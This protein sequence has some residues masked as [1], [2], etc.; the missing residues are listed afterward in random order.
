MAGR[1]ILITGASSGIGRATAERLGAQGDTLLLLARNE[2][3]LAEVATAIAAKGGRAT[4]FPVDLSDPAA[5]DE[6]T[7]RIR[8]VHGTPDI[9]VNNAGAGRWLPV[10]ETAIAEARAMMELPYL[11][12]FQVTRAFL[13]DMTARGSGLVAFVTS[14]AS[15]IVWPNAAAYVAARHALKGFAEALRSEVRGTGVG[16]SLITLGTVSSSYWDHNPGSRDHLPKT[17]EWLL[18]ELS[19]DEAA[20]TIVAALD[21]RRAHAVRPWFLR[22]LFAFGLNA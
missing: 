21:Q 6:V 20:A 18:P 8:T 15:W 9:V 11:A 3:R 12:A 13:P 17:P 22:V 5:V 16:V 1:L 7:E 2:A 14:P 19:P 10:V 4:V